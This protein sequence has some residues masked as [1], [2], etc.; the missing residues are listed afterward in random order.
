MKNFC[1]AFIIMALYLSRDIYCDKNYYHFKL[2]GNQ[3]F[4]YYVNF[5]V[6][7]PPKIQAFLP[8]TGSSELFLFG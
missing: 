2:Y 4:M 6:G 7:S 1:K 5:Y 3:L 8:D